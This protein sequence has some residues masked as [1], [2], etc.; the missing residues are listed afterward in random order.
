MSSTTESSVIGRLE[1]RE[2]HW[3]HDG[4]LERGTY[5]GNDAVVC[6]DCET[7]AAQLW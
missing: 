1:G 2:C 3:C 5:K 6:S 7:P 4:R